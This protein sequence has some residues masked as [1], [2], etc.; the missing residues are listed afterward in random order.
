[1]STT[2]V[3]PFAGGVEQDRATQPAQL[4]IFGATGDLTKRKLLPA[5]YNLA[6]AQLLPPGFCMV[7][8][9]RDD[10][11]KDS[12][13]RKAMQR[14]YRSREM[15][16][17]VTVQVVQTSSGDVV[18]TLLR[19]FPAPR[20]KDVSLRW[21]GRRGMARRV[22][23]S[24]TGSGRAVLV[25]INTGAPAPGGEYRINLERSG[26]HSILLPSSF[27]LVR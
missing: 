10:S 12:D 11:C 24:H 6:Q 27:T 2:L 17:R 26:G 13:F 20:Y 22:A 15:P 5:V 7:G 1:M 16:S 14:V 9:S 8:F 19:N 18:A 3:N 25:P 21:N 4:V 23:V